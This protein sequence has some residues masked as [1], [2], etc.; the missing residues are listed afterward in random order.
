MSTTKNTILGGVVA[1]SLAVVL[2]IAF[3]LPILADAAK[4]TDTFDNTKAALWQ[5]EKLDTDSEYTLVWDHTDPTKATVNGETVTLS[6]GTVVCAADTFL[7]RFGYDST[8]YYFQSVPGQV[9]NLIVYSAGANAGDLTVTAS[10][11]TI[12]AVADK[13]TPTTSTVS[14]TEGYGIVASGDYVMKAPTQGAYMLKDS[15]IFAMGLT[16]ING[17]WYNLFQITGNV[18]DVDISN[19]YPVDKYDISN[20]SI[21]TDAVTSHVD[22]YE[23]ESITFV[24]TDSEDST[25]T[26]DCV[27]NYFIVPAEVTAERAVHFG[28]AEI[29]LIE[30]V[31]VLVIAGLILGVVGMAI[32]ARLS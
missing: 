2:A 3:M 5:V 16:T 10:N 9:F 17:V 18:Q 8:G 31:P 25:I 14:F 1:V 22:L 23:L 27:Y 20:E 13:S 24:A 15:P 19:V 6:N 21:N 28:S 32:R 7:I 4:T 29:A 30:I 12:T 11:G 26:K